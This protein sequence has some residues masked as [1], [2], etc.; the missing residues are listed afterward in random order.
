[1]PHPQVL[2]GA[3]LPL[4]GNQLN[5]TKT[6][7]FVVFSRNLA[8][9][10]SG[11]PHPQVLEG[12]AFLLNG[13]QLNRTKTIP[14]VVFPVCLPSDRAASREAQMSTPFRSPNILQ[15]ALPLFLTCLVLSGCPA[16]KPTSSTSNSPSFHLISVSGASLLL[17]PSIPAQQS[18]EAPVSFTL[19]ARREAPTTTNACAISEGAFQLKPDSTDSNLHVVLPPPKNWLFG[20]ANSSGS[21]ET[22]IIDQLYSFLSAVDQADRARCFA[23]ADTPARDYILQN[24]PTRPS[25]SLFNA[26]GYRI[27]RSGVNLKPNLRLKI[28][29]AYFS[30]T[31]KSDKNYLG[32][33]TVIFD[34]AT[35]S[36]GSL[37]F[38][39]SQPIRYN[40]DSLSQTDNERS[41]DLAI[42]NLKPQKFYRVL[43]YTHQVPTDQNFSAALIGSDDSAHLD[44]FEQKMRADPG[45]SCSSSTTKSGENAPATNNDVQCLTFRGF[46]T[47]SVQIQV[48][49]NGQPKYIDWGTKV[50]SVVPDKSLKSLKIQ[51]LFANSY[52]PIQFNPR[53]P[54]IQDLTL[55]G[56]DHLTW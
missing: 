17:S 40:P 15:L 54:A 33:S 20:S 35:N 46:A 7:S 26:Y 31:D 3:A 22:D 56:A 14:F 37:H 6:I 32:V 1:V 48:E 51:R 45:A 24:V 19:G 4:N 50:T 18:A 44:D 27:E 52:S 11:V 36:D 2:A 53:D 30:T 13:N 47:V 29:R 10:S 39:Q 38:Q 5:R 41:R 34:I 55:V 23:T 42:L 49:L 12:A 16:R 28:E 21:D 25:D 43:F 9:Q 8:T